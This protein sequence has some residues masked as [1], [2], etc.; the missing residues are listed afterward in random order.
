MTVQVKP[1]HE[2]VPL[3]VL[4]GHGFGSDEDVKVAVVKWNAF[5]NTAGGIFLTA[6]TT[7][8]K[9]PSEQVSFE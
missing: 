1:V 2:F 6:S 5:P 4:K 3:N 9:R 8:T 7:S